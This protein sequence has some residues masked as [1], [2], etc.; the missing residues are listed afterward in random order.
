MEGSKA[1]SLPSNDE[2]LREVV[3][4]ETPWSD[5]MDASGRAS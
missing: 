4:C 1:R 5:A 3:K 2:I